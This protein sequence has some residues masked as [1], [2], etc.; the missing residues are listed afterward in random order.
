MRNV[1]DFD[2]TIYDGD[3]TLNFYL[4]CLCHKPSILKYLP[5][6]CYAICCYKVGKITK[7]K[8]KEEFYSFFKSIPDI[9]QLVE[10]F[11]E[12]NKN[13][14]KDWYLKQQADNDLVIS[15]SPEFLLYPICEELGIKNVIAS[16][17]DMYTGRYD[18]ENCYGAEKVRRFYQE[19]PDETI[20]KF[21]SDS[22]SDTPLAKLAEQAYI[23][24]KN[25]L[26]NWER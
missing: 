6:Q 17:V 2:K 25:E 9:Q 16:K 14:I 26:L 18:G 4:F 20:G 7:T 1:Y 13:K 11:W 23:V 5:K 8:M 15:A 21:Y 19:Y 24:K 10:T 12:K 3:S 22:Y